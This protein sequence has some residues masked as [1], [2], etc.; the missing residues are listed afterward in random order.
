MRGRKLAF[1]RSRFFAAC[2]ARG[3]SHVILHAR[4]QG[5]EG[6]RSLRPFLRGRSEQL[7]PPA[8]GSA[9]GS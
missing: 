8:A 7:T 4:I 3:E 9:E 6:P 2:K 5:P 1:S